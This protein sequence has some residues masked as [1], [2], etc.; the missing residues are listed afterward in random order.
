MEKISKIA[1]YDVLKKR[2][3]EIDN[4]K[5]DYYTLLVCIYSILLVVSQLMGHRML[6]VFNLVEPG[7]IFIFPLVYTIG[8]IITELY[9]LAR[10]KKAVYYAIVSESLFTILTCAIIYIPY[11]SGWN[12]NQAYQ[13]VFNY[14][15]IVFIANVTMALISLIYN[16]KIIFYLKN[17]FKKLPFSIRSFIATTVGE[18]ISTGIIVFISFG[19]SMSHSAAFHLFINMIIFKMIYAVFAMLPASWVVNLIRLKEQNK[20]IKSIFSILVTSE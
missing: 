9:G 11:P 19:F 17:K 2:N 13:T 5:L 1:N 4:K 12:D 7:G 15:G 16:A 8:D 18:L 10:S 6:Y 3:F 14:S 20:S